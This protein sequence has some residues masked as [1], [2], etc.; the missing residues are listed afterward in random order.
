MGFPTAIAPPLLDLNLRI[1]E[2]LGRQ[3]GRAG[4]QLVIVGTR[5]VE[6]RGFSDEHGFGYIPLFRY[7]W[8]AT[9]DGE[10]ITWPHDAHYNEFGNR[11]FADAMYQWLVR[12][13]RQQ[14][15]GENGQ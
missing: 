12:A 4:G 11:V 15:H 5:G 6:L 2:E 14:R 9:R 10:R 8:R 7:I 1:L 13:D 3:V